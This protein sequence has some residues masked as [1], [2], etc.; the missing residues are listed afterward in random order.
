MKFSEL[1][2]AMDWR[3]RV[4][5]NGGGY[6]KKKVL[7]QPKPKEEAEKVNKARKE[8]TFEKAKPALENPKEVKEMIL[9]PK[10]GLVDEPGEYSVTAKEQKNINAWNK[11]L[12]SA[13]EAGVVKPYE[14]QPRAVR[15]K[16]RQG[17]NAGL[18]TKPFGKFT[19]PIKTQFG[20][21]Y[22]DVDNVLANLTKKSQANVKAWEKATGK[23]YVDQNKITRKGIALKGVNYT[24]LSE[25]SAKKKLKDKALE[26]K[27]KKAA[28]LKKIQDDKILKIINDN[29]GLNASQ[30]AKRAGVSD[31]VVKRVA[32]N[33]GIDLVTK[34][35]QL[36]PELKALDKLIKKNS[37][38]LSG[39]ASIADKRRFLFAEMQK[40]FGPNYT[41][42]EFIRRIQTLGNR[43]VGQLDQ[44]DAYKGFKGPNNYK[45]SALHKNIV[46]M[47]KGSYL[48]VSA[49]ARLLGLPKNQIQL[50]DDVLS[51]ASKL[52][53]MKV[54]GD[55]TDINALMKNFPEY[56]KNFTRIN[57]ISDRLNTEKL[58]ADNQLIKLV[59]QLNNKEIT[60][61]EFTTQVEEIRTNF[62]NKTKVPIGNPVTDARG[63]VSL[64]FQTPRLIDLKNPK[65]KAISN[66]VTN[67]I[68]QEGV[69]FSDF[70][71]QYSQANTIKERF[72]LLKNATTEALQKSKIIK[73]FAEMSGDVGQAAKNI[74]KTKTGK[75]GAAGLLYTLATAAGPRP[76]ETDLVDEVA[77]T[78]GAA[79]SIPTKTAAGAGLAA[80]TAG[81]KTGRDL[82]S[83][84]FKGFDRFL[85]RPLT[86]IEAPAAAVPQSAFQAGKLI[87]DVKRG[88]QTD[89]KGMDITLPTSLSSLAA[90]KK[91]GLDLFADN[92]GRLK[93][94]LRAGFT[95]PALRT[96]SRGSVFA[97]P[98]IETGIQ[99]YNAM[100]A[101]QDARRNASAF[102][103]RVDTALGE[104]PISYYNRIMSELPEVDRSGAAGGGIMKMAGKSSGPAP[105]SGPTPQGLDFLMKH[106]R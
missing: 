60:P 46:G 59:K 33:L 76:T 57:I 20:T 106:G 66:A 31:V 62:T 75:V 70:D 6:V 5:F 102:E 40:Q 58:G 17:Q 51:G 23:K 65:N 81:T 64:D 94:F 10:R 98:I 53:K 36:L 105:E 86:A 80:A 8:K 42:D 41:P 77:L 49:E 87:G 91:F 48:G 93:R 85:L 26:I 50:L 55:H 84:G 45:G 21:V 30:I 37:K 29:P 34:Y 32:N 22:S 63:N 4:G 96:L 52:T 74:L 38:F 24:P 69:K 9:K 19:N 100:K 92:A 43:Y 71:V 35:D 68:E 54:A 79:E 90:S 3:R 95:Q 104:A 101:L 2:Q 1:K 14:E 82:F 72:N 27:R 47:A 44:I 13:I 25:I 18:P 89:V 99:G 7:P 11:R 16:I 61:Q 78:R 88:E 56:K 73:G 83:K 97:T 15:Y 103:P 39:D 28:K 67:L 12:K